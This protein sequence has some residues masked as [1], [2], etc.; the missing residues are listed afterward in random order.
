MWEFFVDVGF[1]LF[2]FHHRCCCFS[3]PKSCP[4]LCD[5]MQC[6][7]PGLPV[8]HYLLE[9]TQ[10]HLHW[11]GDA[12][13]PSH[14]LLPSSP[15]LYI[16]QHQGLSQRVSSSLYVAK[17]WRFSFSLSLCSEYSGLIS[18]R[19]DWFDLLAVQGI[20]KGLLQHH[21]FYCIDVTKIIL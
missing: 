4:T 16:S 3:D 9:L 17:Y 20:L 7:T 21:N 5:P 11:V 18:F 8:L 13:Q 15:A 1:F 19:I 14:S 2:V 6:S 12:I 10:T